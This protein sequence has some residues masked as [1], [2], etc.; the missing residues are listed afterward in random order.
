[1]SPWLNDMKYTIKLCGDS[2]IS[3]VFEQKID[4]EVNDQVIALAENLKFNGLVECIPAYSALT[5]IYDPCLVTVKEVER[6]IASVAASAEKIPKKTSKIVEIPVVYG[7]ESGPDMAFVAKHAGITEKDLIE[8][9]ASPLY[10]VYMLGFTPGFPYLGGLEPSLETPRLQNPRVSIPE[11]S[12][13]IAGMQTGVYPISSPGGWQIIGKTALRLFD[14]GRE[15]PFL[16]S[17]GDYI[18]FVPVLDNGGTDEN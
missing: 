12:V 13:G 9:H 4:I 16:L 15:W 8:R 5:V 7:G 14:L 1:M 18:R 6:C 17:A 3:L 2:S 10:R 11:G